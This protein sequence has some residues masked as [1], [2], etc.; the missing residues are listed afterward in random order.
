MC[1]CHFC[2]S[3]LFC[4][5]Y[6]QKDQFTRAVNSNLELEPYVVILLIIAHIYNY[7]SA[8]VGYGKISFYVNSV[9]QDNIEVCFVEQ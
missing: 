5:R 7:R 2:V 8:V 9:V 3:F 1:V 6:I 4:W